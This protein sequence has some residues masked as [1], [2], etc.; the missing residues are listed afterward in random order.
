[1]AAPNIENEL[2]TG[3]EKATNKINGMNKIP[4]TLLIINTTKT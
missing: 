1:M 4:S 2:N 3:F